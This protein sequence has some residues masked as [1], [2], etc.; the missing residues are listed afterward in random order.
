MEYA[1]GVAREDADDLIR[2]GVPLRDSACDDRLI[3]FPEPAD[4]DPVADL[5]PASHSGGLEFNALPENLEPRLFDPADRPDDLAEDDDP[6]GRQDFVA[7]RRN[8]ARDLPD[9]HLVRRGGLAVDPDAHVRGI[10]DPLAVHP[11][12]AELA[13][14]ADE[15]GAADAVVGRLVAR[16]ANAVVAAGLG[17]LG[18]QRRPAGETRQE[19][20]DLAAAQHSDAQESSPRFASDPGGEAGPASA[21]RRAASSSRKR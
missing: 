11:D 4:G 20:Q 13:D 17:R 18:G 9:M 19:T 15:A 12:A 7:R 6:V 5:E 8:Q 1:A 3:G 2:S 21:G 14:R 10:G 16:A